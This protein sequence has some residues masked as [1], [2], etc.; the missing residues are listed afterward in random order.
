MSLTEEQIE[1]R[2]ERMTDDID[3]RFMAGL[4]TRESYDKE[5]ADLARWADGKRGA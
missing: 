5:M 1:L 2:V 4:L 3:R